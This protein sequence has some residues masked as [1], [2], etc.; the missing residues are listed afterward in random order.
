MSDH[1]GE[2]AEAPRGLGALIS[3][4]A[5]EIATLIRSEIALAKAEL[6]EKASG[7]GRGVAA[8]MAGG[9]MAFAGVFFLLLAVDH[10]LELVLPPWAA[11]L[12]V[13][14]TMSLGGLA[15][16]MIGRRRLTPEELEPAASVRSLQEDMRLVDRHAG[17]KSGQA[18]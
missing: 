11:A 4:L 2:G 12:V 8:I 18:A 7:M 5:H 1:A 10:A 3:E 17:A 14:M 16:V 6:A 9:M 15:L 13:G